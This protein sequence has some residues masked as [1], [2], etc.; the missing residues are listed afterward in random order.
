MFRIRN[1]VP[2]MLALCLAAW[3]ATG[4]GGDDA[5]GP[6]NGGPTAGTLTV[7]LA[8]P[9]SDDGAILFTVTGPDMTQVAATDA[10]LYFRH[11]LDGASVTAVLVGDLAAGPILTFRVPDVAAV[12]SYSAAIEQVADRESELRTSLTG[13]GLAVQ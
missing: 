7:S 4:C 2:V 8:T 1:G 5:T 9:G 10:S 11:T 3:S 6:G 13:Y 12:G